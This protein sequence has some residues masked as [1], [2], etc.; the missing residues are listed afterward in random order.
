MGGGSGGGSG[1][2]SGSKSEMDLNGD[3][4]VTSDEVIKY[5]QMQMMEKMS[6]QMSS[7][8]RNNNDG[9]AIPAVK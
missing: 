6:D 7:D 3:G 2:S 8:D 4:Q 1:S 9:A 5:M